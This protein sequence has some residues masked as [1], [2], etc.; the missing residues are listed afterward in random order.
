MSLPPHMLKEEV[1]DTPLFSWAAF[2]Y[3]LIFLCSKLASNK[4]W[5]APTSCHLLNSCTPPLSSY[6]AAPAD[7]TC[8]AVLEEEQ[9]YKYSLWME[10]TMRLNAVCLLSQNVCLSMFAC[11]HSKGDTFHSLT[12]ATWFWEGERQSQHRMKSI[13]AGPHIPGICLYSHPQQ[14]NDIPQ[15]GICTGFSV[16]HLLC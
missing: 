15:S 3:T 14:E 11:I 8:Q 13:R 5:M 4:S 6:W 1:I 12:S 10:K 16:N 7:A 9:Y 2:W